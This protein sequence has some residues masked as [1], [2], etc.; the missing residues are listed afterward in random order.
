MV[1]IAGRVHASSSVLDGLTLLH[2]DCV[3]ILKEGQTH[4]GLA[5]RENGINLSS[6]ETTSATAKS[7]I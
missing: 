3:F 1:S 6:R 7:E 5:A 2:R 4:R